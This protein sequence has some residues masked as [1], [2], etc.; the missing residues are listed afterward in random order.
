MVI[1]I[2][3]IGLLGAL[4]LGKLLQTKSGLEQKISIK[5]MQSNIK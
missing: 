2:F 3:E 1:L 5:I 4:K